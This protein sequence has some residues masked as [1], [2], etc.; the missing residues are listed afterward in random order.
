MSNHLALAT[1]TAALG[2]VIQEAIGKDVPMAK[3]TNE[4]PSKLEVANPTPNVNVF[5]YQATPNPAWRNA[6][7]PSRRG[8]GIDVVQ[9]PRVA[10]DLH[11]L[12][13]F[14][15][16]ESELEPQRLL[17][18]V[19][20]V[21]HTQPVLDRQFIRTL[22]NKPA[23]AFLKGSDLAEDVEKVRFVPAGLSLEE[24]S[25]LWS[26]FF[27]TPYALSA[28]YQASVVLIEAD[29]TAQTPL[30]VLGREVFAIT[31]GQPVIEE[32]VSL[33]A[34]GKPIP[35]T[36]GGTL[37]LRGR[38]LRGEITSVVLM[39]EEITLAQVTPTRIDVPLTSPPFAAATLRAGGQGV[40]VIQKILM[41][42]KLPPALQPH[43]AAE[44]NLA[45]FV[46][47]PTIVPGVATSTKVSLTVTPTV[48]KGQRV[49]LLLNRVGPSPPRAYAFAPPALLAADAGNITIDIHDVEPGQYFVHLQVDGAS[50]LLE[51]DP[52]SPSFGPTVNI[53]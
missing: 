53:S 6:D 15:G 46:L 48:R 34:T 25:K 4:R 18:S 28:A 42:K 39:G 41:N 47:Q 50:S 21:L 16:N 38:H 27:Q 43:R 31:L 22:V 49:N 36:M 2:Q 1:V 14:Q 40:Q 30:P 52:A 45:A 44:S 26:V 19:A 17:G 35:I 11:Y 29:V 32:V 7:L 12:L 8:N 23:F 3:V 13:T 33:D 37:T 5:L 9:R 10:L 20:R 24:L 51:L